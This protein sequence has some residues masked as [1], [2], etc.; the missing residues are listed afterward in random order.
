MFGPRDEVLAE[1][2]ERT[3]PKAKRDAVL[4]TL[5]RPSSIG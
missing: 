5:P 3:V 1:M 2:R 4:Q